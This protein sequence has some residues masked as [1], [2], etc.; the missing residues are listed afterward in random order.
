MEWNH[1]NAMQEI[2]AVDHSALEGFTVQGY[3][4]PFVPSNFQCLIQ[5]KN[6]LSYTYPSDETS[7]MPLLLD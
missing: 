6:L 7:S 3:L 4:K 2:N 5:S 1:W